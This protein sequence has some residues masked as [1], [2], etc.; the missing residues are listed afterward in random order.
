MG[1]SATFEKA[2][3]IQKKWE[4]TKEENE[5]ENGKTKSKLF[6]QHS[7]KITYPKKMYDPQ[8]KK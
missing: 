5:D 3:G 2:Y 1:K 6:P 4:K 8:Q 7:L